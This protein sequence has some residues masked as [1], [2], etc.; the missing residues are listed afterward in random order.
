MKRYPTPQALEDAYLQATIAQSYEERLAGGWELAKRA[1][2]YMVDSLDIFPPKI[3]SLLYQLHKEDAAYMLI[4]GYAVVL[5]G[6]MRYTGDVDIWIHATVDN[7][8]KIMRALQATGYNTDGLTAADFAQRPGYFAEGTP[9]AMVELLNEVVGPAF[10]DVWNRRITIKIQ[11]LPLQIV[12]LEDLIEMKEQAVQLPARSE[13]KRN[14]DRS[15][16]AALK[17]ILALRNP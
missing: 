2:N 14:S 3:R 17:K 4:G 9:P 15:D 16:L 13:E 11:G 12:P 7:G 10:E 1:H 5:Y 8:A 6:H